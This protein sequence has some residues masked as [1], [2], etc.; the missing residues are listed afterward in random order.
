MYVILCIAMINNCNKLKHTCRKGKVGAVSK[1][2][3]SLQSLQN[4]DPEFFE[5]LQEE[6]EDLLNFGE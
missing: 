6:G 4:Q 5:F 1:H 2:Q 3:Q